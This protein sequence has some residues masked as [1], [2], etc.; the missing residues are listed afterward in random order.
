MYRGKI[1]RRR[2]RTWHNLAS[3]AM[4]FVLAGTIIIYGPG[5]LLFRLNSP[6]AEA[7]ALSFIC[8]SAAATTSTAACSGEAA[9][10]LLLV[11]AFRDNSSTAPTL[12]TGFTN[13][14]TATN[15]GGGTLT[16]LNA[17]WNTAAN[18]SSGSGTWTNATHV[19]MQV[20]RGQATS[21]IGNNATSGGN[22]SGTLVTYAA[23]TLS[24]T[25]GSSWFAAFA[26]RGTADAKMATAP[27][28][29]TN[30][31]STPA[32]P[33]AGGHDT[34]GPTASNWAS[35]NVTGFGGSAKFTSIVIEIKASPTITVGTSGTQVSNMTIPSTGNFVG[36]A[37]TFTRDVA[38]ANVTSIKVTEN[39]TVNAASNLANLTLYYKQEAVC[40]TSFPSSGTTQFNSTGG[41]FT[42][43]S[44]TTY[45]STVTGTIATGTSQI[46]VYA[47]VDVGSGASPGDTVEIQITNPSTD[48]VASAGAVSPAT[49]AAIA[50]TTTLSPPGP[51][52]DQILRGGEWFSGGTKQSFFWA[53]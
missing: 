32:T 30:R 10:D 53:Q 12:A 27:T 4:A 41:S 22:N 50:G 31:T 44:G 43:V 19:I 26:V 46:C 49:A 20:Y 39:G 21:P 15:S 45:T 23:D 52:T 47:E 14:N 28:G 33:F 3:W 18:S 42:L 36:G 6:H 8:A 17:G 38:S 51:T 13:I 24:V 9:G 29:M 7:S 1:P 35:T 37:F 25:D 40:E 34:N 16:S 5:A 11:T 48:V 2:G